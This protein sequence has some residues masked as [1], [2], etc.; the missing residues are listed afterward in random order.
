MGDDLDHWDSYKDSDDDV[1]APENDNNLDEI[2]DRLKSQKLSEDSDLHFTNDL[3]AG[4]SKV[5]DESSDNLFSTNI[6]QMA[7][8]DP[9]SQ[10]ELKC[11]KD[12]ETLSKKL[13]QKIETSPAKSAVWLQ[14][15]DILLQSCEKKMELKDLQ[16]YK[17]K[18]ENFIKN[19]EN[20]HRDKSLNK[21][22]P[23]D[24]GTSKNYQDELDML[25]GEL[26]DT[27]EDDEFYYE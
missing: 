25:Y 26:S 2:S 17:R 9:Y 18:V 27:D 22:K 23:N 6:K 24:V 1:F 7:L 13:S 14:F 16:T 11:L 15:L 5:K 10:I 19:K 8:A 12:C 20:A 4:Y 21:K 3:F